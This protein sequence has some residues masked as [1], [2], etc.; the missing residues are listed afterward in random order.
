M[1]KRAYG[2][3]NVPWS[4][5]VEANY[6]LVMDGIEIN[7]NTEQAM[8]SDEDGKRIVEVVFGEN[9]EITLNATIKGSNH[10]GQNAL[11]NSLITDISDPDVP[12]PLIVVSNTLSKA[13]GEWATCSMTC[14]H[15]GT[16]VTSG[17]ASATIGTVAATTTGA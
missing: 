1:A 15:F 3:I 17:A 9:S 11:V 4:I 8:L 16:D 6:D 13:K 10:F 2:T 5:G 7:N 14:H 12:E